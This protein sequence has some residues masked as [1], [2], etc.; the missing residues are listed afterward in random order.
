MGSEMCIRDR[1][2]TL[3]VAQGAT[4]SNTLNVALDAT[5][6]KNLIMS[7]TAATLRHTAASGGLTITSASGYVDVESVRFTGN[8]FGTTTDSDLVSLAD[9]AVTITGTLDTT[10]DFR[11]ATDKFTVDASGNTAAA[12]TLGVSGATSL[13]DTLTV[14][15]DTTLKTDLLMSS[16]TAALTHTATTGGL[17][18]KSTS[19]YVDVES[20]RF[21]DAKI[22]IAADEDLVNLANGA[23]T[24]SG[25][26]DATGTFKVATNMFSVDSGSGNTAVA[27]TL[28]VDGATTLSDTLNVAEDMTLQKNIIMSDTAAA[29]TH[30]GASGGL[31]ISS[32]NANGHVDVQSVRFTAGGKMGISTDDDIITLSSGAVAVAG[33]LT[34]SDDVKLSETYAALTHTAG[35]GGLA[36]TSEA[37]Y[38]DVESVRFTETKIGITGDIDIITLSSA[39][40]AVAGALGSTGD[41]NVATTSFTVAALSGDTAVGGDL[42]AGGTLDVTGAATLRSTLDVTGATTL[43]SL[44][45][46]GASTLTGAAT[47]QSTLDVSGDTTLSGELTVSGVSTISNTLTVAQGATLQD[48]LTVEGEAILSDTL[49]V[50]GATTLSDTLDVTKNFKVASTKFTVDSSTGNTAV[51][52]TLTVADTTTL[53]SGFLM[54]ETAAAFTHSATTV[55]ATTGLTI[56][57]TVGFVDV[58]DVRFTNKK[59]GIS[60]DDD[61]IT[62]GSAA[63]TIDGTL[64]ASDDFTVA[65]DKFSVDATTGNSIVAGTLTA[66]SSLGVTGAATMSSTLDVTE[67]TTLLNTLSVGQKATMLNDI[68]MS[69]QAAAITHTATTGGLTIKSTNTYVDVELIR[70]TDKQLGIN[71]DPD[72]IA[73]DSG[74]VIITGTLDT[75]ADFKVATDKFVVD[76]AGNTAAAGTLGVTGATTLDSTLGVGGITTLSSTLIV[77][78]A[79]TLSSTLAVANDFSVATSK[80]QVASGTGNTVVAGTLNVGSDF[81]VATDKFT[82]DTSGNAAVAGTLSV[83]GATTII[84][85]ITMSKATALIDHTGSGGLTIK[86]AGTVS[87]EDVRFTANKIGIVTDDDL[88]SLADNAVTISGTMTTSGDLMVTDNTKFAVYASNGNTVVGG[89]LGVTGAATLSGTLD[90]TQTFRV[91]TSMFTVEHSSGNTVVAGTLAVDGGTTLKDS[92]SLLQ[93]AAT[94]THT[95][96]F[97]ATAGLTISSTNAH[98]DVESVRFTGSTIGVANDADLVTLG[99]SA[100]TIAGTVTSTHDLT[101]VDNTK[102]QVTADNGN[103]AVGGTLGV[104]GA[105][106]LTSA[107]LSSTL[108]VGGATTL[109]DTLTV[110]QGATLSDTLDVALD[111]TLQKN[112]I[113]SDT[114]A[115]LRH[116]AATGGLTITSASGYVDVESV[117]FKEKFIGISSDDNLI[118]LESGAMTVAGTLSLDDDFSVATTKFTVDAQTGDTAVFGTSDVTGAATLSDTLTVAQGATLSSTLNVAGVATMQNGVIMSAADASLTHSGNTG[119]KIK[120]TL[121]HVD[122]EDIRFSGT[123]IGISSDDNLIS[124]ASGAVTVAG[125]LSLDDDF[126]VATTKFTVDAQTGD[127]AVSGT[128]GVTG[129]ATLSDTLTVTQGATLSSTLSVAGVATMQNDIVMEETAASLT[130]TAPSGST[131]GLTI[132]STYGFVDVE[133]VRFTG[134]KIGVGADIDLLSL[135]SGALTVAGTLESNGDLTVSSTN[136]K[137]TAAT[138]DTSVGGTLDVTAATTLA[139]TLTVTQGTTL[140]NTLNVAL[141][142][143]LQKNL[144]MSDLSLIHI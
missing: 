48:S 13:S 107:S 23:V 47:L 129:E 29:L 5:L 53:Q 28:G 25:T 137:V 122:V 134:A 27:G 86:S 80:F 142:A 111:A 22:G 34:V 101:V 100:V 144:I 90:V 8:T 39:S 131:S 96:A 65:G 87:V 141:D 44:S 51:D 42:T 94:I 93:D 41:F 58:E 130:H 125:T 104:T 18:I 123:Q 70:F 135:A 69:K 109:S 117:R 43:D 89:T 75:T 76:A 126:R 3:T 16:A 61:L 57:S 139:D 66:Q 20:I 64:S 60:G 32:S 106:T 2:N 36:I 73:L 116:S 98:V 21:T 95:A 138:G 71:G 19:R 33:T 31:T 45:V 114:A 59:I 143:T 118:G 68:D 120:S 85:D 14:F 62:L 63:V 112:L 103:T 108:G 9:D 50:N 121:A 15:Q 77:S 40:V 82:V 88:I 38:V 37:G 99:V 136:F 127:T 55:G 72:L 119:L 56:S 105:T 115:T 84:D 128:F 79:A 78:G 1:S 133:S 26:L 81:K 140:S 67:A 92:V 12:G 54:T 24:I 124:L 132:K 30:S 49:T 83:T 46:S 113:M 35:S 7:D 10:A 74:A 4:L 17:T 6:Q 91:A 110:T 102:F 11:V 97:S 52:G